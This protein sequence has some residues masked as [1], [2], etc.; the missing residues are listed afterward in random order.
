MTQGE[1]IDYHTKD[2]TLNGPNKTVIFKFS[3]MPPNIYRSLYGIYLELL[4]SDIN[5]YLIPNSMMMM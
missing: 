2:S 3:N 4:F 5:K 1:E